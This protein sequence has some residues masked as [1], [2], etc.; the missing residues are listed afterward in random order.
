MTMAWKDTH[1]AR[2]VAKLTEVR[3]LLA[4]VNACMLGVP[5]R[6]KLTIHNDGHRVLLQETEVEQ[7]DES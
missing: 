5:P 4:E 6:F 7:V 1:D 3:S 2:M